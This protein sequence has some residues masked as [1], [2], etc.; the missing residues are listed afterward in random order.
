M[1]CDDWTLET[2]RR[3]PLLAF[4]YCVAHRSLSVETMYF[5]A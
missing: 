1:P 3:C 2:P 5:G 4:G